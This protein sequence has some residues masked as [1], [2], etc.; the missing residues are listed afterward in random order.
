M[1]TQRRSGGFTLVELMIAVAIIGVLSATAITAFQYQQNRSKRT[2]AMTNVEAIAKTVRAFFGETGVYPGVDLYWPANPI[3][4]N[5]VQWDAASNA[6]FGT[7]GFRAESSVFYRYDVS[8]DAP[9]GGLECAPDEFTVVALG[10]LDGDTNVAAVGYFHAGAAGVPCPY[11]I[12]GIPPLFPPFDGGG[13]RI[14]DTTVAI[15]MADDY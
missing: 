5:R 2:E 9:I 14:M 10:D 12:G 11:V 15:A 4:P 8:A 6:A 3:G 13:N 7:V 1:R